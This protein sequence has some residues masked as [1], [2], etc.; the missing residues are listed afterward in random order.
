MHVI[1]LNIAAVM[2]IINELKA[3]KPDFPSGYN[4][5]L[6]I[7]NLLINNAYKTSMINIDSSIMLPWELCWS[8]LLASAIAL[9]VD[10]TVR[11]WPVESWSLCL[12]SFDWH[13]LEL[14]WNI[15]I[16]AHHLKQYSSKMFEVMRH[17]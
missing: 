9:S 1:D 6:N 17:F 16:K 12:V 14:P 11:H 3:F 7:K 13:R 4:N 15:K 2:R 8:R 10:K 5:V